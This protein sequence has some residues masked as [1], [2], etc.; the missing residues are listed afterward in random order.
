MPTMNRHGPKRAIL[1]AT[2]SI[3]EQASAGFSLC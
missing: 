1:Y 2:V 3:D